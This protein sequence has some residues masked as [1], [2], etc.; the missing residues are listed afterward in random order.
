MWR[1]VAPR[2][3][4]TPISVRRSSTEMTIT[5]AMPTPPTSRATPPRPSSRAVSVV[6]GLA[7]WPARASDGPATRRPPRVLAGWPWRRARRAPRRPGRGRCAR[8]RST[9][10][11]RCRTARCGDVVADERRRGRCRAASGTGSRM[12]TTVNHCSPSYTDRVAVER[13]S[14]PSRSA[15]SDAEHDGRVRRRV[16]SSRNAPVRPPCRRRRPAAPA[17]WPRPRCRRSRSS[18]S[19]RCGARSRR[20]RCGRRRRL[21]RPD[22]AD[23]RRWRRGQ[24]DVARRGTTG[25]ACTCEQV[26]A[27][28]RR[29]RRAGRPGSTP[30]C[31]RPPPWRRCRWRCRAR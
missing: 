30:R 15:A 8:R 20:R 22:A 16:A 4:R 7:P 24:L 18:G 17:R 6:V 5:L 1:R 14:M 2:A 10:A 29:A 25:P 21:D 13:S 11:R 26:R 27:E 12:P 19:G 28:A 3:R 23:H 31:R 9:A